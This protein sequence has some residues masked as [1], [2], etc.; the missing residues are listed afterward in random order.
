MRRYKRR[1]CGWHWGGEV[2]I[3]GISGG[4]GGADAIVKGSGRSG[5]VDEVGDA[6]GDCANESVGNVVEGTLDEE[7][8]RRATNNALVGTPAMIREQIAQRFHPEDRLMLWFDF[9]NHDSAAVM[10]SMEMFHHIIPS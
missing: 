8:V 10:R 4:V 6:G 1:Y 2:G 9:N 7:K 5:N 3:R